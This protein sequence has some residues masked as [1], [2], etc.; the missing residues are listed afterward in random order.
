MPFETRDKRLFNMDDDADR[1]FRVACQ[2][3]TNPHFSSA[4]PMR[5]YDTCEVQEA[6]Q[7]ADADRMHH[8]QNQGTI[9]A[10]RVVSQKA[11]AKHKSELAAQ[12]CATFSKKPTSSQSCTEA[13]D[14]SNKLPLD[15]WI[16]ILQKLCPTF[17]SVIEAPSTIARNII[18]AQLICRT[19][20]AASMPAWQ[21][22]AALLKADH[23]AHARQ[24][25]KI[26]NF[27]KS[28]SYDAPMWELPWQV[29]VAN[30]LLSLRNILSVS[31]PWDQIVSAPLTIKNDVLKDACR[32]LVE[33][34][35]G[36]KVVLVLRLLQYFGV[37][38]PCAVP[39]LVLLSSVRRSILF[40]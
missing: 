30:P 5:L 33:H 3:V 13:S 27:P 20:H 22:L 39:A 14:D 23:K 32:A 1:G 24:S 28:P 18:Q 12:A 26:S 40:S 35:S 19:T 6:M 8:E 9:Q 21:A 36:V 15:V 17:L 10:E 16:V 37:K 25:D 29:Q 2:R 38:R 11:V 7:K 31:V 4:A 34:V